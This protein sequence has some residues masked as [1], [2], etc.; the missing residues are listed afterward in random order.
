[1][2]YDGRLLRLAQERYEADRNA[3]EAEQAARRERIFASRPRL[4]EIDEELRRT[5]SRVM[6]AALRRG[7]DP[8]PEVQRLREENLSLQAERQRL[9]AE[10]GLTE[11]ELEEAP[12]CP[13]C[14][15]TG[16][17]G[18]AGCRCLKVYY[19]EEQR[20]ELS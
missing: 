3:R 16:Y 17:R 2:S 8:L 1:M 15:D 19:V 6:A 20:K 18:G 13:L 4:R 10:L 12:L 7:Q 9:L 11:T 14:G 5:A